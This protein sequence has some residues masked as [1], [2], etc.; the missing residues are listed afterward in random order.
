MQVARQIIK[1]R[2]LPEP[3]PD[4]TGPRAQG[5]GSRMGEPEPSKAL[6]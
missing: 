4:P 6:P 5:S 2:A 3:C 1:P